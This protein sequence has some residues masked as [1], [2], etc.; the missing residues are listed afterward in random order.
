M[1]GMRAVAIG[2]IATALCC[3]GPLLI[4]AVL[5]TG[6]GATFAVVGWWLVRGRG[7]MLLRERVSRK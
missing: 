6:A 7:T 1:T 2:A 4:G 3:G 5:A